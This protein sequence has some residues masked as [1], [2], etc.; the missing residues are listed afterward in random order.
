MNEK[1][2]D[3]PHTPSEVIDEHRDP[4]TGAPHSHPTAT[5]VGAA[6]AGVIATAAG[7]LAAG[8]LGAVVGAI[9]GSG[10]GGVVGHSVGER[11][12]RKEIEDAEVRGE[13]RGDELHH[14]DALRRANDTTPLEPGIAT[15]DPLDPTRDSRT[16]GG[17]RTDVPNSGDFTTPQALATDTLGAA[18]TR[19]F[20]DSTRQHLNAPVEGAS[21]SAHTQSAAQTQAAQTQ[22]ES[23][24][25]PP[26]FGSRSVPHVSHPSEDKLEDKLS[27]D[28]S[29]AATATPQANPQT[30]T[31][32][33]D[34]GLKEERLRDANIMD[35]KSDDIGMLY[36]E[37]T[38]VITPLRGS[39]SR[40]EFS[41]PLPTQ[42]AARTTEDPYNKNDFKE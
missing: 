32:H 9:V 14:E 24:N 11:N 23:G 6:A 37:E 3:K 36:I 10:A 18:G 35:D 30:S 2:F 7:A 4:I 15:R 27:R 17:L 5:G 19:P 1:E 41:D 12:E 25:Y 16:D 38:T 40:D 39:R 21:S 42:K 31:T 33:A 29:D 20:V 28:N 22:D 34:R 13:L 26:S 8:P